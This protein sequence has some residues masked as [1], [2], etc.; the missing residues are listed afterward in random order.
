MAYGRQF[1]T[2]IFLI[3]LLEF[4]FWFYCTLSDA[5]VAEE[6]YMTQGIETLKHSS[7]AHE[8][9][10][11]GA[12][13]Q[14]AASAVH[15]TAGEASLHEPTNLQSNDLL[16]NVATGVGRLGVWIAVAVGLLGIQWL[17]P[18]H[19][20]KIKEVLVRPDELYHMLK[21]KFFYKARLPFRSSKLILHFFIHLY[22]FLSTLR[23]CP[24]W[25]WRGSW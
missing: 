9:E 16:T 1:S 10:V 22:C 19:V 8:N 7:G 2:S 12:T 20:K 15:Q 18:H 3:C 24:A 11:A 17:F 25:A 23:V 13:G 14:E 4:V 21:F 5:G 6:M